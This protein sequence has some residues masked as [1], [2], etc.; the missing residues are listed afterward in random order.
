M[1]SLKIG[2]NNRT[3]ED[4]YIKKI[5]AENDKFFK[6]EI[7]LMYKA[8]KLTLQ[9]FLNNCIEFSIENVFSFIKF[10]KKEYNLYVRYKDEYNTIPA[11]DDMKFVISKKLKDYLNHRNGFENV[12]RREHLPDGLKRTRD[13]F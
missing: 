6:Y 10:H 13:L 9:Y 7:D 4:K 2:G 1:G 8:F 11:H 3:K 12:R 5:L